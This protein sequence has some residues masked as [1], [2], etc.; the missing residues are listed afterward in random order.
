MGDCPDNFTVL[1]N[2]TAAHSLHDSSGCFEQFTIRDLQFDSP[3]D[4]VMIQVN[5][6][7]F[8]II[9]LWFSAYA[10]QNLG[11][12]RFNLLLKADGIACEVMWAAAESF[13]S[14]KIPST[15]LASIVPIL[16]L[17]L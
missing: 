14:P 12:S 10:A 16:L 17:S 3:V 1:Q 8:D 9:K 6:C 11:G 5:G 2:R 4:I 7:N 13:S 15:V